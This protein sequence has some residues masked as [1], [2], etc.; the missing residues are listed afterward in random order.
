MIRVTIELVPYGI[1]ERAER[2]AE[3]KIWNDGT[4][5]DTRGNY[6]ATLSKSGSFNTLW[7]KTDIKNFP[8]L[9]K[10]VYHLL[11][12]VL[13]SILGPKNRHINRVKRDIT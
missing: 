12:Q 6:K 8:R 13:D 3:V 1:E 2:L 9:R 7:K 10:N 11:Y 5:G 4:G